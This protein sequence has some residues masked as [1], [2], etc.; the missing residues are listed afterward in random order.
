MIIKTYRDRRI[1]PDFVP[2]IT[3][4]IGRMERVPLRK[5]EDDVKDGD[6][7]GQSSDSLMCR[8][9]SSLNV[10][11]SKVKRHKER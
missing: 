3:P 10:M 7:E 5:A 11:E 6:D 8:N 1:M 2:K 9:N 4:I